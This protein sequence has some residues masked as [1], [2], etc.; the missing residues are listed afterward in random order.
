MKIREAFPKVFERAYPA[1]DPATPM[2][3]VLPLLRFHEIDAIPLS[4]F[5]SSKK[6]RAVFGYSS[7]ARILLVN[8]RRFEEFLKQPCEEVSDQLSV[9]DARG[10]L[11]RL[12][13]A[14]LS[15]RFGFA[16]VV[17]KRG[18][19][20]LLTLGDV[21][22]LYESGAIRT[23]LRAEDVASRIF[24]LPPGTT[25]RAALNEMFRRRN[26]RVFI[27]GT[28][29]F[30]WD[31]AIIEHLFSPAFLAEYEKGAT[32][33]VLGGPISEVEAISALE[34]HGGMKL[35]EAADIL[36]ERRGQCLVFDDKVV[37]PWDVVMKPWEARALK[38]RAS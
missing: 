34:A 19:G 29:E 33:D 31:R 1:I 27:S 4:S 35:E 8:P 32:E 3:S 25:L 12:L 24:S 14:F 17:E 9:V 26:R 13:D 20:G 37:T 11:S 6:Q 38:I 23:R 2:F 21:Q 30:V 36:T 5:D 7:L 18:V 10:P 15:A 22:G 28:T 16:R